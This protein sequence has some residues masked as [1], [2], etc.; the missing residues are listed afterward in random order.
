MK[1]TRAISIRQPWVEMILRGIKTKEYR[2]VPTAIRERVFIYASLKPGDS[3]SD[4]KKV[5][6]APG[7]L[8]VGQIVGTVEVVNCR[9]NSLMNC[10]EYHLARPRRL[11]RPL[12]ATNQPNPI[13]WRPRF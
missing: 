4:W 8:P 3:N 9:R 5:G 11:R 7:D 2:S 6:K 12:V 10:Y 1:I 13:W